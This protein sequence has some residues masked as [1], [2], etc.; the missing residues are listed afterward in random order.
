M[1]TRLRDI[2]DPMR[3]DTGNSI[4]DVLPASARRHFDDARVTLPAGTE[5]VAQGE[6]ITHAFFPTTAVCSM[7]VELSSGEKAETAIVGRDGFVGVTL[8]LGVLV[9]YSSG[10]IQLSGEGYRVAAKQ[11]LELC[12]QHEAFRRALFGYSA[13][14]LHLA[15]L[16]VACNSFH[17]VAQRLARWLLFAHD[18]AAKDEF[19]LTHEALSAMLAATRPRVSQAAAKLRRD[20]I[21]AYRRGKVRILERRR[22]EAVSCECYADT[23]RAPAIQGH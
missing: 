5:L 9:S 23:R 6:R 7:V 11:L 21:I 1:H 18:R 22:L 4:L 17:S 10:V 14:K 20:G 15:S 12:G 16:S 13:F 8:V 19:A 3:G 2:G